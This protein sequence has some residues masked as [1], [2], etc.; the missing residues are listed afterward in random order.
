[1]VYFIA[2]VR[3][4]SRAAAAHA[5]AHA[6]SKAVQMFAV[7]QSVRQQFLPVPA[8]Q[9]TSGH[10]TVPLRDMSEEVHPAESSP[11]AH[12]D[13]YGGQ[14]LQMSTSRLS[15]GVL[16]AEQPAVPF[17]LSPDRQTLQVQLV[18]QVLQRRA[19]VARAHPQAQGEQ[20]PEDAHLPVLR[21]EL[22]AGDVLEQAHA[23]TRRE[24]G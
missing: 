13:A 23:E 2:G 3:I 24:D 22:H 20:A 11:T 7:L 1:M 18:L 19:L 10:Q 14:T 17:A 9:D 12:Q 4:E 8:H 5:G 15:K 6:R 16:P 21:Q